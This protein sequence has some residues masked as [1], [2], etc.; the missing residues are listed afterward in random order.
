MINF[1]LKNNLSNNLMEKFGQ[2]YLGLF[3]TKVC[4]CNDILSN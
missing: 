3:D 4:Q 2:N 1:N